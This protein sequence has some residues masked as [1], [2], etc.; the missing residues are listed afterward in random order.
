MRNGI[1]PTSGRSIFSSTHTHQPLLPNQT[2]PLTHDYITYPTATTLSSALQH[3][4]K[5]N[6]PSHGQKIHA[7]VLKIG[8]RPNANLSIKF[9]ILHLKSC[10]LSYARR[11]FDEMPQPTVSAYNYMISGYLKHGQVEESL[12]VVR[13]MVF[14][15]EKLDGFTFSMILKASTMSTGVLPLLNCS[16]GK[17]VH[18]HILKSDVEFD[19]VLCT[20][21]VDSYVKSGKISYAR[22]VFDMMLEKNVICS[23]SMI[24]GYMNQGSVRDAEDV[25]DKTIEKD[26]VVFNAMI[27]GYSKSLDTAKR[28]LEVFINMRQLNYQPTISTF[29]SVIGA[30][31]LLAS[32][33]IGLQVQGQLV[34]TEFHRDIKLGSALID[35]HSKCGR[36]EDARRVFDDMPEKNVFSWTSMI[37]GYG[38]NGDPYEAIE[39]FGRMQKE[40]CIKP[41]Y[42]TF[43]SA[44][45]ACGH[46]GLVARGKEIFESMERNYSL[47]P[48]ME[49]YACMVDLIGR[50]GSLHQAWE[51]V[52]EMPDKP[53][54]DV[55]AALLSS[56]RLHGDVEMAN[57]AANE[58][59]RLN[60]DD[61]PGAY[62][63]LSN[64]YAAAGKWDNVSELRESMKVRGISK[65]TGSSWVGID[66][67]L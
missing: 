50:A 37:D 25:F 51:F 9:L 56:C 13:R 28:S 26:V 43:L 11:I 57:M 46:A 18:A 65:D 10:C 3:Y 55:W 45:S 39:L 44:L 23:T 20:A 2:S 63:A 66:V 35:M 47:K 8:F 22:R 12:S 7:H 62:V 52:M 38:K 32:F 67:G 17:Q 33:E 40:Y 24:S 41:N 30:C 42:V 36:I 54:S 5:S 15:N 34:K 16:M 27:E 6:Y 49:H 48:K 19:D 21:L 53:N 29:A 1:Y 14:S 61:R 58:L 31:S 4:I 60:T 59:F 64:T